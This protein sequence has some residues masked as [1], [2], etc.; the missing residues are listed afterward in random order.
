MTKVTLPRV[1]ATGAALLVLWGG[2]WAASYAR[3]GAWSLVI[4]IGIA[5]AK[6]ALVILFF[7][8]LV[9]ERTSVRVSFV[10]G[11]A[12]VSVMIALMVLDVRTRGAPALE[13]TS[14]RVQPP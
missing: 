11:V 13:P 1:L 14:A 4:A 7:M 8:E 12:M 10:A 6:A 3:L 9:V 5:V 2:S